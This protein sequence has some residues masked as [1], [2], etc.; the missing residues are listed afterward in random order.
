MIRTMNPC[1]TWTLHAGWYCVLSQW[2]PR[3][4]WWKVYSPDEAVPSWLTPPS[5]QP[6]LPWAWEQA[7]TF[8][9]PFHHAVGRG[10]TRAISCLFQL[11][12]IAYHVPFGWLAHTHVCC[13]LLTCSSKRN[14]TRQYF[15]LKISYLLCLQ[16]V[17]VLCVVRT[18]LVT[19]Y[20]CSAAR[21]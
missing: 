1:V 7:G 8:V 9:H 18:P 21:F 3:P 5:P 19:V 17:S 2:R 15:S 4:I 13:F 14:I 12:P 11:A 16:Q 10:Q 20:V 6:L